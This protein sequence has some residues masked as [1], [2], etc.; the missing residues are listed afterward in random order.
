VANAEAA[1]REA[2]A[3]AAAAER[4][5]EAYSTFRRPPDPPP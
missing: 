3:E 4:E 5:A 2:E 1:V